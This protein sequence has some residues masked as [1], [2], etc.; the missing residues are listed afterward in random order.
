MHFLRRI[1]LFSF[2]LVL[3]LF[4]LFLLGNYQN[5]LDSTLE[6]LIGMVE[7]TSLISGILLFVLLGGTLLFAVIGHE[8]S[9]SV[10]ISAAAGLFVI[11][12]LLF[13]MKFL[14]AWLLPV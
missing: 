14:Q 13:S 9:L 2:L 4:L 7:T 8:F 1:S 10:W 6:F 12:V 5:F 11:I 3:I